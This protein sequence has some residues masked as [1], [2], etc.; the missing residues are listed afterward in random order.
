M[1]IGLIV[2]QKIFY[3]TAFI[4]LLGFLFVA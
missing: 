1:H 3:A 2:L 4:Y